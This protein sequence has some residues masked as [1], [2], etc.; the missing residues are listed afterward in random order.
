[1]AEAAGADAGTTIVS[2]ARV[3]ELQ[4]LL[5]HHSALYYAGK[6]EIPDA[7]F[8]DLLNELKALEARHPELVHPDSPTQRVGAPPDDTVFAPVR[9]EQP[10]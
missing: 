10:M 7:D 5:N 4:A 1:M 3:R 9:H 2:T 8:D 6:P